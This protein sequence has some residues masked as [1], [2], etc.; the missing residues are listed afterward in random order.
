M[1]LLI[2]HLYNL[3]AVCSSVKKCEDRFESYCRHTCILWRCI[4]IR[5]M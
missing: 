5:H 4:K 2:I 3:M 1:Q